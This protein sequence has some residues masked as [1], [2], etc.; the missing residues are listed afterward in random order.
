MSLIQVPRTR[1]WRPKW[2]S[3]LLSNANAVRGVFDF[4]SAAS[5]EVDLVKQQRLQRYGTVKRGGFAPN[6]SGV[7]FGTNSD[8]GSNCGLVSFSGNGNPAADYTVLL[9]V[10]AKDT[11]SSGGVWCRAPTA[12]D[13]RA[14]SNF[15]SH[16]IR[17]MGGNYTWSG[18]AQVTPVVPNKLRIIGHRYN[19]SNGRLGVIVDNNEVSTATSIWLTAPTASIAYR[20]FGNGY[21]AG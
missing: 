16:S 13:V 11:T 4:R 10:V 15:A 21:P 2:R 14:G 8:L 6:V 12:A 9:A 20:L 17:Q 5:A 1:S 3:P 19:D 18:S 7:E